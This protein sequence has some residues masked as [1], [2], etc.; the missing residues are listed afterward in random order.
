[1]ISWILRA[2][3]G[4]LMLALASAPAAISQTTFQGVEPNQNKFEATPAP[5]MVAG[6]RLVT[7]ETSFNSRNV[8]R[9]GT[10]P[11]PRAIYRHRLA[12]ALQGFGYFSRADLQG[13]DAL[14]DLALPQSV[15][16]LASTGDLASGEERFLSWYGFGK[17]EEL[18]VDLGGS[19]ASRAPGQAELSTVEVAPIALDPIPSGGVQGAFFLMQ[20]RGTND[21]LNTE[22]Q[23]FDSEFTPLYANGSD[24]LSSFDG[25]AQLYPRLDDGRYYIAISDHELATHLP[26]TLLNQELEV[27]AKAMDFPGG[28]INGSAAY[29][30]DL[31]LRIVVDGVS[32]E[33]DVTKSEPYEILWFQLDVGPGQTTATFC[34]G[35]GTLAPCP[36]CASDAPLGAGTGCTNSTGRGADLTAF[37]APGFGTSSVR[38]HL[39]GMPVN[40]S[41]LVFI[42]AGTASPVEIGGGL[43]CLGG[44]AYRQP[45]VT[46]RLDGMATL[47]I[48]QSV[49]PTS[50]LGQT[51][52]AQALYRDSG[53]ACGLNVTSGSSF[54]L[55]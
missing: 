2:P 18:Y 44:G 43:F 11:A 29:P 37:R 42:S 38:L 34:S 51:A 39:E 49:F 6:D 17:S 26:P 19:P 20:V 27:P 24:D 8:F 32:T 25:P 54:L 31:T 53:T 12:R 55:W 45:I 48:D 36:A 33:W 47:L 30:L 52:Y 40:A 15:E 50:M 41:A 4:A 16:V 3:L 14:E 1:M 23:I 10:A 21:V 13:R 46:A 9:V 7:Q 22:L 28:A 35:D 5:N